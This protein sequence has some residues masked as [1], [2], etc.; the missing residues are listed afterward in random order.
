KCGG[1][2]KHN[3]NSRRAAKRGYELPPSDADCHLTRPQRNHTSSNVGRVS[4]PL[5][6]GNRIDSGPSDGISEKARH[7]FAL[8][9]DAIGPNATSANFSS[10]VRSWREADLRLR[11]SA[12]GP[13][14]DAPHSISAS[15]RGHCLTSNHS[16]SARLMNHGSETVDLFSKKVHLRRRVC[17]L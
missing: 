4:R 5:V 1:E 7:F 10:Q 12:S 11:F 13:E 8:L 3:C 14:A 17:R 2:G 6:S 15:D 16:I 9:D